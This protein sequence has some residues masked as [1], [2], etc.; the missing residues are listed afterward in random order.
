[1]CAIKLDDLEI[2]VYFVVAEQGRFTLHVASLATE[3][4]NQTLTAKLEISAKRRKV[5]MSEVII[6]VRPTPFMVKIIVCSSDNPDSC[7]KLLYR[8]FGGH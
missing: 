4:K 6:D 5:N 8:A 3:K 2:W 1:M 7:F